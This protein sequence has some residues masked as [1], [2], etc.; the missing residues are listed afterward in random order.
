MLYESIEKITINK[1]RGWRGLAEAK[2]YD[3][4]RKVI[5][6]MVFSFSQPVWDDMQEGHIVFQDKDNYIVLQFDNI[7]YLPK[8]QRSVLL[9]YFTANVIGVHV[10]SKESWTQPSLDKGHYGLISNFLR[11]SNSHTTSNWNYIGIRVVPMI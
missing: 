2:A 4:D 8:G 9:K 5:L 10:Y 7:E 1:N 3:D 6:D 11:N